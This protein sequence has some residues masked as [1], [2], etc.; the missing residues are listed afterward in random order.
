MKFYNLQFT[1]KPVESAIGVCNLHGLHLLLQLFFTLCICTRSCRDAVQRLAPAPL[2]PVS[3]WWN[4]WIGKHGHSK[5]GKHE[6]REHTP[7]RVASCHLVMSKTTGY[8]FEIYV[9]KRLRNILAIFQNRAPPAANLFLEIFCTTQLRFLYL[10]NDLFSR[11]DGMVM[12]GPML[13][14]GVSY[15]AITGQGDFHEYH[16][17]HPCN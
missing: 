6:I 5:G 15:A 2:M 16:Q 13:G 14:G 11:R 3:H 17:D 1:P 8:L 10:R 7:E 9:D 4:L 12:D